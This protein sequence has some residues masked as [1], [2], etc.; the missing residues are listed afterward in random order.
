[1][2][3]VPP[4]PLGPPGPLAV[5]D[6]GS[7]VA[8]PLALLLIVGIGVAMVF[9]VRS[10]NGRVRRMRDNVDTGRWQGTPEAGQG[11]PEAGQGPSSSGEGEPDAGAGREPSA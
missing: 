5:T 8:G 7:V 6:P 3:T 11:T 9:L 4:G 10:M 2:A 1:M